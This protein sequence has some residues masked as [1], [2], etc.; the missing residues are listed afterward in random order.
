MDDIAG[1]LLG[2]DFLRETTGLADSAA[3]SFFAIFLI[4]IGLWLINREDHTKKWI[5]KGA[6]ALSALLILL[7]AFTFE[8]DRLYRYRFSIVQ[9]VE[10]GPGG[11]ILRDVAAHAGSEG[12]LWSKGRDHLGTYQMIWIAAERFQI[13]DAAPVYFRDEISGELL[14]RDV[15]FCPVETPRFHLEILEEANPDTGEQL[16]DYRLV[17]LTPE[18]R[19]ALLTGEE[20][21]DASFWPVARAAGPELSLEDAYLSRALVLRYYI[22]AADQGRVIR[23]MEAHRDTRFFH[24]GTRGGQGALPYGVRV[25]R[26][27]SQA[28]DAPSNALWYGRTVPKAFAQRIALELIDAGV[29]LRHFG[30]FESDRNRLNTLE[31]GHSRSHAD[32]PPLTR[33]DILD[34]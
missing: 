6:F 25:T 21:A 26:M 10:T 17:T 15:P 16:R 31:V 18:C 32:G 2:I 29:S 4:G 3:P 20:T 11:S 13:G 22:K 28:Q 9:T 5:A 30:P 24:R 27:S 8:P 7:A 23:V 12:D 1:H 34:R 19:E 14:I 33:A